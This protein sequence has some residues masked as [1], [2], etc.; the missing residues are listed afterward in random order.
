MSRVMI[1]DANDNELLAT[2][3]NG[4]NV[5]VFGRGFLGLVT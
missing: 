2:G 3:R 5:A 4:N 1:L